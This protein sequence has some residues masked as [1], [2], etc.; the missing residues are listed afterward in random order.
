QLGD[1][2]GL[3]VAGD[4][5]AAGAEEGVHLVE[6]DDDGQPERR[7]L[8]GAGEDD[9]DLPLRLADAFVEQLGALDVQ[10]VTARAAAALLARGSRQRGR[11]RLGDERLAAAGRSVEQHPFGR[12]EAVLAV[13]LGVA[14]GQLDGVTDLL[15]LRAEAA[16]VGV[17]D[18]GH[19]LQEEVLDRKSTR[20]NSSHVKTSY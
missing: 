18:V 20:L 11:D 16:D 8:P 17:L 4:A 3:H 13:E 14:E 10:A 12:L 2:G 9:P 15:D 1:D 5:G 7:L 6:E 19:L